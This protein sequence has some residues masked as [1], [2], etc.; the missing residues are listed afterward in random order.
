MDVVAQAVEELRPV[1]LGIDRL[2]LDAFEIVA[3]LGPVGLGIQVDA[4]AA[5]PDAG[6]AAQRAEVRQGVGIDVFRL[7]EDVVG[8]GIHDCAPLVEP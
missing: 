2:H 1:R 4:L 7:G 6:E 5:F 8:K 3:S